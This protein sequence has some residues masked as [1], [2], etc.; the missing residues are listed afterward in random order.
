[1]SFL[2]AVTLLVFLV[3]FTAWPAPACDLAERDYWTKPLLS[4]SA[5]ISVAQTALS[6]ANS[7]FTLAV[8]TVSLNLFKT[9]GYSMQMEKQRINVVT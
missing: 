1:M 8:I 6:L 4:V 9:Q 7:A 2:T 5:L 3:I